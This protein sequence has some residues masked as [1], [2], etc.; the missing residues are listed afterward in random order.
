[1]SAW[2]KFLEEESEHQWLSFAVFAIAVIIGAILIDWSDNLSGFHQGAELNQDGIILDSAGNAVMYEN[3]DGKFVS[4]HGNVQETP[5]ATCLVQH[6]HITFACMGAEGLLFFSEEN[7]PAEFGWI[8]MNLGKNVT[9][10]DVSANA[11]NE[12]LVVIQEG[13]SDKLAAMHISDGQGLSDIANQDGNMHIEAM[14]ATEEGWLIGGSWQAPPNWLGTNPA[15]PPMYE[16]VMFVEWDGI[17]APDSEIV[18]LGGEGSI[19]GIFQMKNGDYIAT[20]TDD[21]VVI[22]SNEITSL[23]IASFSSTVDNNQKVWLF[24]GINSDSVAIIDNGE[25]DF[26]ELPST[27]GL[28]PNFIDCNSDGLISIYGTDIQDSPSSVSIESN[29]RTSILSLRGVLDLGFILVSI[30][31]ISVMGWNIFEAM[32]RGE[33]F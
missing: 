21:T 7:H 31:I 6:I 23:N 19:H 9:A 11:Q 28:V 15:S 4:L 24:G 10:K 30:T 2:R 27:L 22:N 32:R 29:A 33:I 5:Y 16:L 17:N 13:T 26:E 8:A 12:L 3:E 14:L 1:M 25:I 18:Y 20:G